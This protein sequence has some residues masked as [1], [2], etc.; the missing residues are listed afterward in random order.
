MQNIDRT[1]KIYIEGKQQRSDSGDDR[2]IFGPRNKIIG[3]VPEGNRKDIRD[4][5]E[6]ASLEVKWKNMT[7][8]SRAQILY[9]TAENLELRKKEFACI[10]ADMTGRDGKQEVESSLET[11]FHYAAWADKFE[12]TIHDVPIRGVSLAMNEPIGVI[13]II[14]P[15]DNLSLIHISEPTRPY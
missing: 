3:Q 14:C 12:G 7:P 2:K 6:A 13:G 10:I 11:I 15:D 4:A 9:Y 1:R 5:V 8:H